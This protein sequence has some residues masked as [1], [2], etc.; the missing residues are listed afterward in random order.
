MAT[1]KPAAKAAPAADGAKK[2]KAKL[3]IIIGA[4]LFLVVAGGGAAW[5]FLGHK[6]DDGGDDE[7]VHA[8]AKSKGKGKSKGHAKAGAPPVFLPMDPYT[9]NLQPGENG[10][11]YLQTSITLQLTSAEEVET[12]KAYQPQIRSRILLLLSSKR[13]AELST[14]DGKK[15]LAEEIMALFEQPF[16]KGGPS[17]EVTDVLFTA[18]VIQ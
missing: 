4:V 1:S 18:F 16:T 14:V 7:E 13:G 11:Q 3:F 9:V 8:S 2:S 5:F 10:D 6:K 12:I 15:K 17:V